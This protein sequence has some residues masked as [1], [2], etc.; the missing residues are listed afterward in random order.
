[1]S[2]LNAIEFDV[3]VLR[4][5]VFYSWVCLLSVWWDKRMQFRPIHKFLLF[6]ILANF[7]K[8]SSAYAP[9]SQDAMSTKTLID[10][11]RFLLNL[12]ILAVLTMFHICWYF[13]TKI[14]T[15]WAKE[16]EAFITNQAAFPNVTITTCSMNTRWSH[17]LLD[18]RYWISIRAK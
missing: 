12:F 5:L 16:R 3:W 17:S 2:N 8:P 4:E 10:V 6:V 1:M 13:K 9:L 7:A 15:T 18:P 11:I 14:T